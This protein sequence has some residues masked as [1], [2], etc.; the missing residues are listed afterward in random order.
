M[1]KRKNVLVAAAVSVL[2]AACGGGSDS[3]AVTAGTGGTGTGSGG[4][5]GATTGTFAGVYTLAGDQILFAPSPDQAVTLANLNTTIGPF[6]N[7]VNSPVAQTG[8]RLSTPELPN[9]TAAGVTQNARFAVSFV[10]QAASAAATGDAPEALQVVVPL[11]FTTTATGNATVAPTAN[12]QAFIYFK[13]K[14]GAAMN[15]AVSAADLIK[16]VAVTGDTTS[17]FLSLDLDA[18]IAKAGASF[19]PVKN[20]SGTFDMA[21]VIS[22]VTIKNQ[23]GAALPSTT[24]TVTGSNQ[25]PIVGDGIKGTIAIN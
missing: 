22:N 6:A 20:I 5:D 16:T 14:A 3:P 18:A 7:G 21:A 2:L 8:F 9:G 11:T 4:G 25:A 17:S 10:E 15:V 12:G 1:F 24:V 19:A 23:A 13:P